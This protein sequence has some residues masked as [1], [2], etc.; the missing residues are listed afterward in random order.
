MKS[1]YS[2][3]FVIGILSCYFINAQTIWTG[4]DL[5]FSKPA[6][7]DWTLPE[8]QDEITP[9]ISL[10]RQNKIIIYNYTYWQTTF[11]VDATNGD[12]CRNFYGIECSAAP[13][14]LSFTETGGPKGLK[15]A[16]LDDTNSTNDWSGFTYYGSLGNP[17]N[18]Y[19]FHNI[20]AMITAL[21]NGVQVTSINSEFDING[22]E[23]DD[24][25]PPGLIGKNLG[26][27]IEADDVYFTLTFN[28]WGAGNSGGAV[29][30][31]R[32]TDQ[33][34]STTNLENTFEI[35]I[36][37]NPVHQ[38]LKLV[39]LKNK[40]TYSIFDTLGKKVKDGVVST[41]ANTINL[42]NVS[43]GLY[44]IKFDNGYTHKFVKNTSI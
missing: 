13:S 29:S 19:S 22:T 42:N 25:S 11:S 7:A 30:Y 5:T 17:S 20:I 33:S 26:V 37:P 4:S 35:K 28:E 12:V 27:W 32:S 6:G 34:L 21:E 2:L 40:K 1:P 10:T 3:I 16:I 39:G 38:E 44:F 18:F 43:N 23:D 14:T 36:Y 9:D 41:E 15:W 31:T 8:N 24:L